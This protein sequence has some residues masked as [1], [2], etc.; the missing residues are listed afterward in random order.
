MPSIVKAI[1]DIFGLLNSF[2]Q[3]ALL[4]FM[5]FVTACVQHDL[6]PPLIDCEKSTLA[7]SLLSKNDATTCTSSDGSIRVTAQGGKPPYLFHVENRSSEDGGFE[8]LSSG[9]YTVSVTDTQGCIVELNNI[10]IQASNF[11]FDAVVMENTDCIGGNGSIEVQVSEGA[12]PFEYRF[13]EGEFSDNNLFT[14]LRDGSYRLEVRDGE[15]CSA[16][17]EIAVSK[18]VTG[19][20]WT[21]S[22]RP[23][24]STHCAISGCH[25]GISRPDLRIYSQSK[26][27]ASQIKSLTQDGSMPFEGS[28]TKDQID[29]I[30]CWVDEGAL[31]N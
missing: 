26:F 13:M 3:R 19:T 16:S 15:G 31:E 9:G 18:G 14:S 1:F 11:S 4:L 12:P 10:L 22:I 7:I 25:N 8:G 5:F 17:L 21:A 28:L 20:S 23:L 24:I 29:L 6:D 30:A 27:Y 2:M